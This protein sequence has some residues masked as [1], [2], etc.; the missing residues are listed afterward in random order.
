MKYW[1][2]THREE[3]LGYYA[4][5]ATKEGA[6]RA[7]EALCG[8]MKANLCRVQE[9]PKCPEGYRLSDGMG[10]QVLEAYDE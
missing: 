10:D 8:P 9:L 6:M 3:T 2:I 5:A 4:F 7:V 1:L